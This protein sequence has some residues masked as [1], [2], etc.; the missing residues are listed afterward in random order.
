MYG[1]SISGNTAKYGG[2]GVYVGSGSVF[3]VSGSMTITGN[4]DNDG[5]ACNVQLTKD[6]TAGMTFAIGEGGLAESALIGVTADAAPAIGEHIAVATGADNGYYEGSITSDAGGQ[7][8]ILREG[9]EINLYN[10]L[11]HKHLLCGTACSHGGETHTDVLTWTA[12]SSLSEI[13]KAGH[14]YLTQS[15]TQ[16]SEW[17]PVDGVVLCLNGYDIICSKDGANTIKLANGGSFTLS[18]CKGT[19]RITHTDGLTGTGVYLD[20]AGTFTMYG[21]S[22]SGNSAA[23][24]GGGVYMDRGTFRM[25]GGSVSGNKAKYGGGVYV[26][27][28]VFTLSGGTVSG[29]SSDEDGAGVYTTGTFNMSGGSV[30]GNF[31]TDAAVTGYATKRGGG[32]YAADVFN[33]SGGTISDNTAAEYGGGVYVILSAACTITGGTISGNTSGNS[34]GGGVCAGNKLTVSGSPCIT[35]N[36]G[37]DGAANNVYLG[38]RETIHVGGAL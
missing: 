34:K 38:R 24:K 15:V 14:Y 25:L 13:T 35:G 1:G 4:T 11:P 20:S 16:S 32:V 7:Y 31:T 29:N 6:N 10:G 2:G 21:G 5:S 23:E 22:I 33:M 26:Y 17:Q 37:K 30:S 12:V 9:D 18:D 36:L 3:T 28:G 27:S 8:G 19:G